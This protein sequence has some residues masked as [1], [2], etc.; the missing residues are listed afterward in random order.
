[1]FSSRSTASD[2]VKLWLPRHK[3]RICGVEV[4]FA[5]VKVHY[6]TTHP[7]YAKWG[8]QL[9]TLMWLVLGSD[10]ALIIVDALY[11][12]SLSPI[13]NEYIVPAYLGGT[14]FLLIG[15]HLRKLI[16]FRDAW[17]KTHHLLPNEKPT[18]ES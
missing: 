1:M 13:L 6:Q 3:C 7:E 5:Q 11:L 9:H 15:L 10:V 2:D 4:E 8:R 14:C 18:E 16:A 12:R 17:D